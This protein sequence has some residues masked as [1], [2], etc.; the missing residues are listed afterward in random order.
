M[1][2]KATFGA[3]CFWGVEAAFRQIEGVTKTEVGFE[4]G[5]VENPTYRQVCSH[6]TGHA[7]VVQVTYDPEQVS[8]DELLDVFWRKHNPN[9]RADPGDQ[10]RSVIFAHDDDQR[11]AAERSKAELGAATSVE[12]AQTFYRAEESHQQYYEKHGRSSCTPALATTA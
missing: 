7:E 3:A 5:R 6:R 4:G 2:R 1:E 10:Y 8:Y 9:R 11:A 12:P